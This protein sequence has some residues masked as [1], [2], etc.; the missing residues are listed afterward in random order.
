MAIIYKKPPS[1]FIE[2]E[3][4]ET[5]KRESGLGRSFD[6]LLEDNSPNLSRNSVLVRRNDEKNGIS[7]NKTNK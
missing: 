1:K 3:K 4:S 5:K 7:A 6:S 2:T